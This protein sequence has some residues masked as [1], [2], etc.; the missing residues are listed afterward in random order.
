MLR[1]IILFAMG[2]AAPLAFGELAPEV[3]RAMQREAPEV[4]YVEVLDVDID[5]ELHKP[6]GCGFFDFEIV[7]NVVMQAKV[8]RVVRSRAG[9]RPGATIGVT[10]A[11]VRRCSG[12]VGPRSIPVLDEGT[13]TYA[14]LASAKRGFEPAALGAS[15]PAQPGE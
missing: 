15:F 13:K 1:R 12:F 14:Y 5:R 3:Y 7:R 8:L 10:Y 6:P 11:S 2:I 9:V 4:L